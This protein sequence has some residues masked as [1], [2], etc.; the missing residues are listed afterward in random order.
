MAAW[1]KNILG[2]KCIAKVFSKLAT[3]Y[4]MNFIVDVLGLIYYFL[5][6]L[7]KTF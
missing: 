7:L 6:W 2:E 5:Q 3:K 4:N 1:V